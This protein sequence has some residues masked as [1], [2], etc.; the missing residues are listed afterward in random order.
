MN[1]GKVTS[2]GR[3]VM[4]YATVSNAYSSG[5]NAVGRVIANS[6]MNIDDDASVL[7][8]L[9]LDIVGN[10]EYSNETKA[11]LAYM[12][13]HGVVDEE[14]NTIDLN[15]LKALAKK[16]NKD[17]F[18]SIKMQDT[19][20]SI[21]EELKYVLSETYGKVAV[22]SFNTVLAHISEQNKVVNE[23]FGIMFDIMVMKFEQELGAK[24]E[25]YTKSEL[26]EWIDTHQD[27]LPTISSPITDS[28]D[29]RTSIAIYD[30][31][32]SKIVDEIF[33]GEKVILEGKFKQT[34]SKDTMQSVS[35]QA[36]I[37]T[38]KQAGVSGSVV[39]IHAFD[40]AMM[41]KLL[42]EFGFNHVF[43]AIVAEAGSIEKI[44][45][46]KNELFAKMSQEWNFLEEV[47]NSY[48]KS[49]EGL[50]EKTFNKMMK[51]SNFR[52]K[53]SIDRE[54]G[55]EA[56]EEENIPEV[57]PYDVVGNTENALQEIVS[58]NNNRRARESRYSKVVGQNMGNSKTTYTN[59]PND[60]EYYTKQMDDIIAVMK[61]SGKLGKELST[62]VKKYT[63]C[64]G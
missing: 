48:K 24:E 8:K 27:L 10:K 23:A 13:N 37:K 2:A 15:D 39:P 17:G 34:G 50:D 60:T 59:R 52:K 45:K 30:T 55:N 43:D 14:G 47:L 12:E 26:L 35:A 62:L 46:R 63:S 29:G 28:G 25:G 42:Q 20:R 3:K 16:I 49:I 19:G 36:I 61:S 6:I 31:A 54:L 56:N 58:T 5:D 53:Y 21:E 64:E 4:K 41:V 1:N 7:D 51:D 38:F 18:M 44:A 40:G 9:L 57:T 22:E 32:I 33:S 11:I